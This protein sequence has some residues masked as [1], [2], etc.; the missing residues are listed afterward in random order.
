MLFLADFTNLS[1]VVV[2]REVCHANG[3]ISLH[4]F[5]ELWF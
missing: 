1:H 3:Y 5:C 4:R 2:L